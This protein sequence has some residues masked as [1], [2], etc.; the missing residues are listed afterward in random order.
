MRTVEIRRHA[1]RDANED[2]TAKGREQCVRA[3]ETLEFP[4]DAYVI[5]PAKRSRLTMDAFGIHT[6]KVHDGLAPRPRGEFA[7][8]DR[9]HEELM[10]GGE[11]A[12]TAWFA[13]PECVPLLL[14]HGRRALAAV[15]G[16][17][18]KLPEGGRAL[19]VSHGGTIEPLAVVASG[20]AYDVLFGGEELGHCEGVRAMFVAAE[21]RRIDVIRFSHARTDPS[22]P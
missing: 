11:D 1:E 12:V 8:Y 7:R 21:V 5:S 13:I 3:R 19:A 22:P 2:L 20:R 18:A 14:E 6:A 4:Y 15:L 17:A 9:R 16:I 10:R